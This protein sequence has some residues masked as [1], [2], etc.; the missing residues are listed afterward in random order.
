ML[1]EIAIV[2][3]ADFHLP[4]RL[5]AVP[6]DKPV[7]SLMWLRKFCS[8]FK[9]ATAASAAQE[10]LLRLAELVSCG[11]CCL[12]LSGKGAQVFAANHGLPWLAL[13]PTPGDLEVF[14]SWHYDILG[15]LCA[16]GPCNR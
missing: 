5:G 6:I 1:G 13:A 10:G 12:L 8:G 2:P 7:R 14:G 15:D 16:L 4:L 9:S 3:G 11:L